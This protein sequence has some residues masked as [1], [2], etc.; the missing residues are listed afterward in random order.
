[1]M[2]EKIRTE[3]RLLKRA[4]MRMRTDM[5]HKGDVE[6]YRRAVYDGLR[7][8]SCA[9][10]LIFLPK[11]QSSPKHSFSGEHIHLQIEG[12]VEFHFEGDPTR[13]RVGPLDML[14]H[15][16]NH[17]YDYANVGEGDALFLS[18]VSRF[19]E[20]PAKSTSTNKGRCAQSSG[21]GSPSSLSAHSRR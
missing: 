18:V 21:A 14:F 12:E 2:Q 8:R 7:A 15:P 1:M 16:A 6:G 4:D 3:P 5:L 11:G 10:N 13:Y 9:A 17:A 19:E 20:W